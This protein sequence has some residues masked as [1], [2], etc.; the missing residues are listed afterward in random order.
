MERIA[1]AIDTLENLIAATSMPIPN[2]LIVEALREAL[3][4][5]H[6][7]L[8]AAYLEAGGFNVWED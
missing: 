3:P 4:E 5:L 7:E 2:D 1:E 6:T 8:K